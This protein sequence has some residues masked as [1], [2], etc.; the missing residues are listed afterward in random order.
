MPSRG[1]TNF[2]VHIPITLFYA[3]QILLG[4]VFS[5]LP[6]ITNF[7]FA[8]SAEYGSDPQSPFQVCSQNFVKILIY[9]TKTNLTMAPSCARQQLRLLDLLVAATRIHRT[10]QRCLQLWHIQREPST[11]KIKL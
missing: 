8:E 4:D 10:R 2:A 5:D 6:D 3:A 9:A 11:G 1:V 7:T